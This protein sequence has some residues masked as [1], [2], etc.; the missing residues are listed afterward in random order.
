MKYFYAL[1]LSIISFFSFAQTNPFFVKGQIIN[2]QGVGLENCTVKIEDLNGVIYW[3][4]SIGEKNVF[5]AKLSYQL[6]EC[7][8]I[9]VSHVAY[10]TKTFFRPTSKGNI[11]LEVVMAL[12]SNN[13]EVVEVK[14]PKRWVR[15]DTTFYR[16]D[17]YKEGDEKKLKDILT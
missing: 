9:S 7:I 3:Y 14:A 17:A 5:N 10:Q 2:E 1:L 15:G 13:L 12:K 16:V 6:P 11:S 8:K 4:T